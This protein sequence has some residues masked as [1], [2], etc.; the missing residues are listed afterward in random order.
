MGFDQCYLLKGEGCVLV[1]AGA[2][3][4]VG[5]LKKALGRAGIAPDKVSLVVITHGHWDHVGSVRDIKELTGAEIAM[6]RRDAGW[7]EEGGKPLSPGITKWGRFFIWI[8]RWFMPFI[9]I[10]PVK[11]DILLDDAGM[12]LAPYGICG[13]VVH[14]PGHT[15]GSV[16]V[17]LDTGEAFVGD[18]AMN[19]LPLRLKPGMAIFGEDEVLMRSSLV[20]LA[21]LGGKIIYPA[22]GK[23]FELERLVR[24]EDVRTENEDHFSEME[25]G[26]CE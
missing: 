8:H 22:H 5:K 17:L 26:I 14:T 19:R 6:H 23:P 10:P 13:C 4:K 18:L 21:Q 12:D 15:N 7:L 16:S 20:K 24:T 9:N 11:V 3:G 1:D 25:R 2:P